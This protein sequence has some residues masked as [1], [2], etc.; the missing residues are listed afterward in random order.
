MSFSEEQ[1]QSIAPNAS[2]FSAGKKLSG[3]SKW[4]SFGKSDRVIWGA[5]RGSGKNPHLTQIDLNDIAFKCSCPSRQFPCKHAIALMLLY[6]SQEQNFSVQEE[7]EWVSAWMDSRK[8]R[9]EKAAEAPKKTKAKSAAK[10]TVAK[11]LEQVQAGAAELELW[12]KDLVRMGLLELSFKSAKDF[13]KV[14]ARMVD[15]KA[16]GLAFWVRELGQLNYKD[17]SVWQDE[18]LKLI[19]KLFLLIQAIK[20]YDQYDSQWQYTIRTL[21]GWSQSSKELLADANAEVVDDHW[22]VV[23]QLEET[24][25][26][27]VTQRN[28]LI[29]KRSNRKA[30][31]LNFSTR[32]SSF[33][34]IILPGSYIEGQ[35]AFFPSV[36]PQR[37]VIKTQ[38]NAADK[39]D[40]DFTFTEN[41]LEAHHKKTELIKENPWSNDHLFILNNSKLILKNDTWFMADHDHYLMPLM[42][43]YDIDKCLKSLAIC[44]TAS[45]PM[46][47]VIRDGKAIPL[48]IFQNNQYT[49]L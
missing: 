40:A 32:F 43:G 22:L 7:P 36:Q 10:D 26:D 13:K 30:L 41:W 19:S 20:N 31:V 39:F 42:K 29:G 44:G 12:L 34:S 14:A 27:I 5:I 38:T 8:A 9:Q 23:G 24:N 2:A 21:A 46:A 28:W 17:G 1:I 37:A 15:A 49:I 48:G 45:H 33:E 35:L 18:S 3:N 25:D 47:V 6:G 4:E 11:R 16:P